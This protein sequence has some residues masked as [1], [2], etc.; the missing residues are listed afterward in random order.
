MNRAG[1]VRAWPIAIAAVLSFWLALGRA[2]DVAW[3]LVLIVLALLTVGFVRVAHEF[4][5]NKKGWR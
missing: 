3:V 4:S 2:G 5:R 1:T